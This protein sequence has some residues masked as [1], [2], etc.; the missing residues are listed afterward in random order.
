M[1]MDNMKNQAIK[2]LNNIE[3]RV[4][5][6]DSKYFESTTRK[7]EL[8]EVKND[9]HSL[10]KH[11]MMN[12]IKRII[13]MMTFGKDVSSLFGDVL[14]VMQ[15][16]NLELKKLIYL[17]LINYAKSQPEVA[18][19]AVNTFVKDTTNNN[20]IVRALA[21][22]T[23]GC[24]RVEE[25]TEY[26]CEPL[27]KCLRDPDPYVRKTA[28]LCVPKFYEINH[29]LC[30]EQGFISSLYRLLNDK[31]PT[32][33]CNALS[34]LLD[35]GESKG[36]FIIPVENYLNILFVALNEAPEWSQIP[37]LECLCHYQPEDEQKAVEVI[38]KVVPRLQHVNCAVVMGSIK[39]I[40]NLISYVQ[41]TTLLHNINKKLTSALVTLMNCGTPEIKYALLTNIYIIIQV[42]PDI[43]RNEIHVHYF[44]FRYSTVD[45]MIH[46]MLKWKN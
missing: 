41:N 19:L 4:M 43:L 15:P 35:I 39:V 42:L 12:A 27:R 23:M 37:I 16:D 6:G 18:I 3:K 28:A 26:L 7:G 1:N 30:E 5:G 22:R 25:I 17:Y 20:P 40:T 33:I 45:M 21:I 29:E 2:V 9:L 8:M 10:D 14:A 13:A 32:V 11:V 38:E 46:F 31:N 24:I 36:Q 34:A 44:I